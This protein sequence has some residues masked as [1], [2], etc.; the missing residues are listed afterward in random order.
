VIYQTPQLTVLS[1]AVDSIQGGK[2]NVNMT[3]IS[4]QHTTVNAYE[5][6]E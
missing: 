6:D 1:K 2:N 4:L 5:A 3:D